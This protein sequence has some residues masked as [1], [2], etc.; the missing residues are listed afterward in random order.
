MEKENGLHYNVTSTKFAITGLLPSKQEV[1]DI[2]NNNCFKTN[3]KYLVI[4]D[5]NLIMNQDLIKGYFQYEVKIDFK[6]VFKEHM[7]SVL[8]ESHIIISPGKTYIYNWNGFP[9]INQVDYRDSD[10][11]LYKDLRKIFGID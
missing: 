8:T 7:K 11:K 6:I 5:M 10:F 4:K 9:T 2:I 1:E 3:C